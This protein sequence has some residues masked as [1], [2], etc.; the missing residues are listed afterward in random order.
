MTMRM[1]IAWGW[2][3]R[4]GVRGYFRRMEQASRVAV[5]LLFTLAAAFAA[6]L[7]AAGCGGDEPNA[8]ANADNDED[9]GPAR[10]ALAITPTEVKLGLGEATT[11]V[12]SEPATWK[13]VEPGGGAVDAAGNY[14]APRTF[15][16]YHVE[17]QSTVDPTVKAVA[18]VTVAPK[19]ELLAGKVG[20]GS[21]NVDG[22]GNAARFTQP[23]GIAVQQNTLYVADTFNHVIRKADLV[24]GEVSL[25][26][27]RPGVSGSQDGTTE[28]SRFYLPSKIVCEAGALFVADLLG[29]RKI[30]L[31]TGT[32][33]T[34][35]G[36]SSPGH[37]TSD[38][39]GHVFATTPTLGRL[40]RLTVRTGQ[41][42]SLQL[43]EGGEDKFVGV[44]PMTWDG[45]SIIARAD[46]A[47]VKIHPSGSFT[48]LPTPTCGGPLDP[49][50]Q[51]RTANSLAITGHYLA[52]TS[53]MTNSVQM[54]DLDD[55]SKGVVLSSV[56]AGTEDGVGVAARMN[57][58]ED[59]AADTAG[60]LYV[61]DR[62]NHAIR[63][64]VV[65]TQQV[66]TPFGA[67]G[68]YGAADGLGET[69]RFFE[70]TTVAVEGGAAYV[71]DPKNTRI[72]R[73]D[74]AT[75]ATTTLLDQLFRPYDSV[76]AGPPGKLFI[77][78]A[79][80]NGSTQEVD[81]AS[82][83]TR[84]LV[85]A[86]QAD[87]LA[88]NGG[89]LF[90]AWTNALFRWSESSATPSTL[91]G[92]FGFDT[93][94][95]GDGTGGV[96][97][98]ARP[99]GL[100]VDPQSG[101]LYVADTGN[102]VIRAVTM[103]GIVTT[104]FGMGGV[105]GSDDGVGTAARFLS[106]EA[107]ALDGKGHL[108]VADTGNAT[109]RKIDLATKTVTTFL[110]QPGKSIVQLGFAPAGLSRPTGIALTPEGDLLVVDSAENAVLI[111]RLH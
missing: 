13:V 106:P 34:V 46:D 30:D 58:P 22:K 88:F 65:A 92:S 68:F 63:K 48:Y 32:V 111:V 20:G 44:G 18:T 23:F 57:R 103:E 52:F 16:T 75:G 71:A 35:P 102:H 31:A 50:C 107:V 19:L 17:A 4:A 28:T 39:A 108:Y 81:I 80:E 98:F 33:T 60:N 14:T 27:G 73:V 76:I 2:E 95:F 77:G 70:P 41:V 69:A 8:S 62:A 49:L 61:A 24:T 1:V 6:P 29:L 96:A 59:V 47:L 64:I 10:S 56:E 93:E 90:A 12:A 55:L 66:T 67:K 97:R 85:G 91:A 87:G 9:A 109:I 15:G 72:A 21:G 25:V 43:R 74:L 99:K 36:V 53:R 83:Q 105:P 11:F 100:A 3:R 42:A 40:V 89:T 78:G 104:P 101:L 86:P 54:L 51:Y 7:S 82:K 5:P 110:G 45:S 79:A 94:G 37:L 84:N 26:A 38:H